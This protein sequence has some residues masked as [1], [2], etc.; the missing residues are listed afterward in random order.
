[1]KNL[2]CL[3]VGMLAFMGVSHSTTTDL[4]KDN[5]R[6]LG[7]VVDSDENPLA[8]ANVLLFSTTDSSL[9]KAEYSLDDGSFALLNVPA[10]SYWLSTTYVGLPDYVSEPFDL[11]TGQNKILGTIQMAPA[12]TDLAEVTVTARKP[13]VEVHP[14]KTVFNVEGSINATG[15]DAMELLRKAPGVIVDN[16]DNVM[17]NGKNGVR[18]F[19]DGKPSQL[20]TSELAAYLRTLQSTDIEAIEVITNP[21]SKYEAEGNA[22]IINIRMKKDKRLGTNGSVSLGYNRGDFNNYNGSVSGNYRNKKLNVFG[23]YSHY[24]NRNAN[25]FNLYREQVGLVYDQKNIRSN[26]ND[27]HNF[28]FGTDLFLSKKST[29]GILVDG[30]IG[31]SE[32][33]GNNNTFISPVG[34]SIPDSTLVASSDDQSSRSN[35]NANLNYRFD[36][37]EG[38][39]WN[40]DADYGLYRN[41]NDQLQPNQMFTGDGKPGSEMLNEEIFRTQAPT[42]IDIVTFKLDHERPFLN[43]QLGAG[44]KVADISTDNDFQFFNVIN[45]EGVPDI[46]RSNRFQYMENINAGYANY[47][48]QLG[49]IGISVG[50]RVEQTNTEGV[51][52]ALDASQDTTFKRDYVNFFPSGGITYQPNQQHQLRLNYSRRIDRP[53]YQNL[54]PF[55]GRLDKLTFQKGNPNLLPQ[56]TNSLQLSHTYKY[57]YNTSLSFS[58]TTD[59]IT[60]LT[61]IDERDDRA[62]FITNENLAQQDNISLS[63]SAPIQIKEWWNMYA[64]LSGY[65]THNEADFGDGKVVDLDVVAYNFYAQSTFNLPAG[66]VAEVSGWY[67]SPSVWGGTFETDAMGAMDVGLQKKFMQDRANLKVSVSDVFKTNEWDSESL[68]GALLLRASGGWDSRRVRV[69]L[70]Y[71]F[72]NQQVKSARR[73]ATGLED[74]SKR[75][76]G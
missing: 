30:N 5:G 11:S 53:N 42:D 44:F 20:S 73:R 4:F 21:G 10:G 43:G 38:I 62:S 46:E 61:F 55:E 3:L 1:M 65:Y 52:T 9:V 35:Y 28:R 37:G 12:D 14:D 33:I 34:I 57:M 29:I 72:G 8:F 74:E 49:K 70:T 19:I 27:G 26:R 41:D 63:F 16:N 23:R 51:L 54:N 48:R 17:L 39:V 25:Y 18:I 66:L 50:L 69:N 32:E 45:G 68:F 22:G 75:V 24:N 56:Y 59:L 47:K 58:R 71:N 6:I 2:T 31:D 40:M 67:N 7:S 60:D 64:N 13:L 76:G 36:N 15:N